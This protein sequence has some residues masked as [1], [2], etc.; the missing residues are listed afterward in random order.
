[1]SKHR[2]HVGDLVRVQF[3]VSTSI[4]ETFMEA[5]VGERLCGIYEV[6]RLLPELDNG[7]PQYRIR[8]AGEPERVVRES[9][10]TAATRKQG[11][12]KPRERLQALAGVQSR[13]SGDQPQRPAESLRRPD[14]KRSWAHRP[15]SSR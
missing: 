1:M 15:S 14:N 9:Q 5:I 2:F 3:S 6:S 12:K 13:Q 4:G 10:L 8:C 11:A 7:E